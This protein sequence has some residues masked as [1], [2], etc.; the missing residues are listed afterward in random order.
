M[1]PVLHAM[2]PEMA[3]T[4]IQSAA[5]GRSARS[6]VSGIRRENQAA[7]QVQKVARGKIARKRVAAK[8]AEAGA[9]VPAPLAHLPDGWAEHA[10]DDG[11]AYYFHQETGS[12]QWD[13][14]TELPPLLQAGWQMVQDKDS[15]EFF[16][17]NA[18]RNESVWT[19][20]L[21]DTGSDSGSEYSSGSDSGS[22]SSSGSQSQGSSSAES[23][24]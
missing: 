20:P 4:K 10:A 6:R 9:S 17:F 14:P 18:E 3:A 15:R 12:T 1:A 8:R 24:T 16:Y 2:P 21:L 11:E 5:R 19:P 7:T 23:N 22:G 13:K